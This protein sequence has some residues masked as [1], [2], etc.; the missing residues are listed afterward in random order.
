MQKT[1]QLKDVL[2]L[3]DEKEQGGLAKTFDIEFCAKDGELINM[4]NVVKCGTKTPNKQHIG[5]RT[6][7]NSHHP[8]TVNIHTITKFNQVKV[9]F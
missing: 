3:M 9:I 6:I 1:I 7:N 8:I 4:A 5:V 2:V